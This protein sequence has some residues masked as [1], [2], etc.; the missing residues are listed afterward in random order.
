MSTWVAYDATTADVLAD[1]PE[2][3]IRSYASRAG[4]TVIA[5]SE[6]DWRRAAQQARRQM[7]GNPPRRQ[8]PGIEHL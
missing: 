6:A 5:A 4:Q 2:G 7:S 8:P 3:K 1:G